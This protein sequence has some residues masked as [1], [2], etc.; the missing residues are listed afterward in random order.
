MNEL[1]ALTVGPSKWTELFTQLGIDAPPACASLAKMFVHNEKLSGEARVTRH[2]CSKCSQGLINMKMLCNFKQEQNVKKT[3]W[4]AYSAYVSHS[5][6]IDFGTWIDKVADKPPTN[7]VEN[8]AGAM[9]GKCAD[10]D[11]KGA[12]CESSSHLS[13]G[14]PVSPTL[15][16][17][18]VTD[19]FQRVKCQMCGKT[20]KARV[21]KAVRFAKC[22]SCG[23]SI[24]IPGKAATS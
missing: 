22:P 12:S 9:K 8:G 19:E 21:R 14:S 18:T 16:T 2:S 17:R 11:S 23:E 5:A 4:L 24:S 3:S 10:L 7:S 15:A 6:I 13:S 1:K 20:F